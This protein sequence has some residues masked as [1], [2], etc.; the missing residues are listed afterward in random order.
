MGYKLDVDLEFLHDM[1]S[2]ELN[3]LVEVLI[4]DKD[5]ELRFAECITTHELYK[6]HFPNHNEY[7]ELI[8]EEIQ[9]FGGNS[10]ANM[11]RGGG[12][13]YKEILCEV[14][15]KM[16]VNYNKNSS[17]TRIEEN[18]FMK[19][20]EDSIEK[21]TVE[22]LKELLDTLNLKT[23]NY[24][25]NALMIG[26][27]TAIKQGGFKS[28]QIALIVANAVWKAIFG[29]GLSFVANKTL[30]KYMS[31]FAGP[32]GWAITGVWTAIDV[33][34][35]AYRVTIP[36]VIQVAFLRQIYMNRELI[37]NKEVESA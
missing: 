13:K 35:P 5:G 15:D 36:A 23:T 33:A 2:E 7:I 9:T 16:K 14:C 10:F 11:L 3:E 4:K 24:T 1:K 32:I 25:K 26:L 21:M 31:I 34:G 37:E 29:K 18:L 19:I 28:Y 30:T 22:D 8:L 17:T 27:Q 20:L 12:V 6:T